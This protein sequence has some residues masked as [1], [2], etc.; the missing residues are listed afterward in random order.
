MIEAWRIGS[1]TPIM[2]DA[3]N[4]RARDTDQDILIAEASSQQIRSR[5]GKRKTRLI[6][7][8]SVPS[9]RDKKVCQHSLD[10]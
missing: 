10:T 7:P 3:S 2:D 8:S 5:Q 4:K 6:R 9:K 1:R